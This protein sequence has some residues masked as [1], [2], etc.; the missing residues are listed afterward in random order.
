MLP[1]MK[2]PTTYTPRRHATTRGLARM[3][4][5]PSIN[6]AAQAEKEKER[7][8]TKKLRPKASTY[9]APAAAFMTSPNIVLGSQPRGG[10]Y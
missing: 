4:G 5:D 6:P 9:Q 10:R 1:K 7:N 8:K 3:P 2:H